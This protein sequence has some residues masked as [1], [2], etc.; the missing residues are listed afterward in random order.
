MSKIKIKLAFIF[1]FLILP[2]ISKALEISSCSL[3]DQ[4]GEY[5]LIADINSSSSI[6]FNITAS[7]I[8][9]DCQGHSIQGKGFPSSYAIY[10]S[11]PSYTEANITIKNCFITNWDFGIKLERASSN[12]IA[13]CVFENN[14]KAVHLFLTR[15]NLIKNSNF[16]SNANAIY[17]GSSSNNTISNNIIKFST[18]IGIHLV[19]SGLNKIYN[20]LLNNTKNFHF[21]GTVFLNYWNTS[22]EVGKRIFPGGIEIGGNYWASPNNQGFSDVCKDEDL[23]CFCDENYF[24]NEDNVDYLPC[25][26]ECVFSPPTTTTIPSRRTPIFLPRV[27]TT[28]STTTST[29]TTTQP[30]QTQQTTTTQLETTTQQ[31][32]T[33]LQ[34]ISQRATLGDAITG[35][36]TA[37]SSDVVYQI[38]TFLFV[39]TFISLLIL[40]ILF[41]KSSF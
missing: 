40:R 36:V 14:Q 19:S 39:A 8:T 13:N 37:I 17:I 26:N 22:S 33:T 30:Q 32:T 15:G 16:T 3:L 4:E 18:D 5:F 29:T 25:S 12:I 23:N 24:L 27:E 10:V 20:N 2:Q 31:T 6:C 35:L 34:E 28:T 1:F 9:L 41:K 21:S 11:F 7:N 38:L